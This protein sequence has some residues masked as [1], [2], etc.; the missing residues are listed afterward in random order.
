M[1][2]AY[3]TY[4]FPPDSP[5]LENTEE[6]YEEAISRKP[7]LQGCLAEGDQKVTLDAYPKEYRIRMEVIPCSLIF[8]HYLSR[9]MLRPIKRASSKVG[10]GT[11]ARPVSVIL[12][13]KGTQ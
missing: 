2:R 5:E 13:R 4:C 8:E 6:S 3:T 1:E 10:S 9:P 12:T 11:S 7:S